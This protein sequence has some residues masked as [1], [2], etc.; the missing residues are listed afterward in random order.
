MDQARRAALAQG[1]KETAA[2]LAWILADA[3]DPAAAAVHGRMLYGAGGE[4]LSA[5][6]PYLAVAAEGG[7]AAGAF[8]YGAALRARAE[9][10][11]H[12]FLLYAALLG[13]GEAYP[14]AAEIFFEKGRSEEGVAYLALAAANGNA[15]AALSLARRYA[16]GDGTARD[17]EIAKWY[18]LQCRPLP[19]HFWPLAFRLRGASPKEPPAPAVPNIAALIAEMLGEAE[20]RGYKQIYLSLCQML[21]ARGN[22]SAQCRLG[23]LYA[24]GYFGECEPQKAREVLL[25]YGKKGNAAAYLTLGDMYRTG[26]G[27]A[28]S[29]EDASACYQAAKALGSADA[30]VRLGD[31][32]A[33]SERTPNC[34]Y[35]HSLYKEA[36]ALGSR[37]GADKAREI[38]EKRE[39]LYAQGKA[40]L[41]TDAEDAY[42]DFALSASMG[43]APAAVALGFCYEEGLGAKK[44]RRRA[45]LW[46]EN[47][48]KQKDAIA[49]WRLGRCYFHGIGV[50]R[51]FEE[52]HRL[53]RHSASLGVAEAREELFDLLERRK[54]KMLRSLYSLGMRLFY[55]G[56]YETAMGV[57]ERASALGVV[58]ATYIL[59]CFYEF[60]IGTEVDRDK[61]FA[62]YRAAEAQGFSDARARV[63]SLLLKMM[64]RHGTRKKEP[65]LPH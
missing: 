14:A 34:A 15:A 18:L 25:H 27:F 64:H 1:D 43:Y 44:D 20:K 55:L 10:G 46:Y 38:E 42:R 3:G 26:M 22:T 47:A 29:R 16:A 11:A 37:E 52:A 9:E 13:N 50:N 39:A 8:A 56:K 45:F 49:Q 12:F 30:C 21:A 5:A 7:D 61:A 65:S 2:Q 35:A 36:L 62:I 41:A 28:V 58:R 57:L 17:A 31:L 33:E 54:K 40:A 60:G 6:L 24:Q 63:K 19:V 51:N 53:L 59:G 23:V 4:K 48:E 32:Y